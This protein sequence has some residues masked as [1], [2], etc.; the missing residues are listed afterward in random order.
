MGFYL[1]GFEGYNQGNDSVLMERDVNG[2][3][4]GKS[5]TIKF[6]IN[7]PL[8][9]TGV[10]KYLTLVMDCNSCVIEANETN[11]IKSYPIPR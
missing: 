9:E 7:L 11:N 4:V 3:R 2:I 8:G 6:S 10:N 5:Q 1:S